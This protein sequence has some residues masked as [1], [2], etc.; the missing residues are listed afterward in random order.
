MDNRLR[1]WGLVLFLVSSIPL[2]LLL[3]SATPAD[4]PPRPTPTPE[5][6]KEEKKP[7]GAFIQLQAGVE[8]AG[9]WS[10]IQW[11]GTDGV[12]HDVDGWRGHV[13]PDGTKTWWVAKEDLDTG[14]F[15]WLVMASEDSPA[16]GMSEP[17]MLP[18][19]ALVTQVVPLTLEAGTHLIVDGQ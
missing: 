10:M 3:A 4:L 9:A 11:Q 12:W 5:A 17:F 18:S 6:T 7:K 8:T 13:E 2:M 19:M 14:P 1:Y 16:V 15:R